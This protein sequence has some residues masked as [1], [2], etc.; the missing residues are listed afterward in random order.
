MIKINLQNTKEQFEIAGKVFEADFSDIQ[1]KKYF[2]YGQEVAE[3]DR[4]LQEQYPDMANENDFGKLAS[5]I[6]EVLPK[7]A[8]SFKDF[9]DKCFGEGQG[10]EIYQVCGESTPNMQKVF[11]AIWQ[12]I[13]NKMQN[14]ESKEQ[15]VTDKYIKNN[16]NKKHSK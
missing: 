13:I 2:E 14:V 4:K 7:R 10:E 16:N 1:L 12:T 15:Q 9:F 5:A 11:E 8:E 3:F 6:A